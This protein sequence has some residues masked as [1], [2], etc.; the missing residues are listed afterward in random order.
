MCLFWPTVTLL[1]SGNC[2]NAR[3]VPFGGGGGL[4]PLFSFT[5]FGD[6]CSLKLL[7]FSLSKNCAA[8]VCGVS[9]FPLH[10]LWRRLSVTPLCSRSSALAGNPSV[11]FSI[12]PDFFRG[13]T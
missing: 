8:S 7:F 9:G 2:R 5:F 1:G 11:C 4:L 12:Q 13:S 6:G 10:P 3:P